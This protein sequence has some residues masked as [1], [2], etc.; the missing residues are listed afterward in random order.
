MDSLYRRHP[1]GSL[2]VWVTAADGADARGDQQ[3]APGVV[4]LL[5]DGQQRITSLY[6]I[7]RGRPP[8]FFD[9]NPRAFTDLYFHVGSEEFRFHQP[10]LMRDDPLWISVSDLMRKG[11]DG[12]GEYITRVHDLGRDGG[13]QGTFIGRLSTILGI[14]NVDLH[15]EEVTGADKTTDVV[16]D[17]FNRVNSGGTKLSQGDLALAKICGSWPEGREHMQSILERWRKSGYDFDLDWLLGT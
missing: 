16:V 12:L 2:L 17:I 14:L 5:L 10:L 3:L 13:M 15:V 1:V 9:G 8:A 11:N 7:A 4:R 6:G